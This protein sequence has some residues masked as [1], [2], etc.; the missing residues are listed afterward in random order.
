VPLSV[1]NLDDRRFQQ[2]VD[3]AKRYVQQRCPEWTDHNVSDPGVTLIETWAQM[4]E[5]VIYRLNR[6]PERL[7]IKFLDLI[8]VRL[9]PA[10]AA[11]AEITFLMSAPPVDIMRIPAGTRVA[12]L[13]TEQDEAITFTTF[14]ELVIVPTQLSRVA[15]Q[16]AGQATQKDMTEA[17]DKS[18]SFLAFSA[19]PRAGDTLVVGLS[20]PVPGNVVTLRFACSI[21]GVGVDPEHVPL[22]WEAWDGEE[23]IECDVESDGTGGLNRA[24]DVVVHVPAAHIAAV[25]DQQRAG[26]LR[27]RITESDAD[28]PAY[29]ASPRVD[30]LTA[31]TVGGNIEAANAEYVDVEHRSSPE[32]APLPS[33][34]APT[35]AGSSGP[36]STTSPPAVRRTSTSCSTP[37]R[38]RSTSDPPSGCRTER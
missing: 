12:T 16:A 18:E 14:R 20:E 28:Y 10:T 37:V 7:Y 35:T 9:Y 1:P 30:G 22:V 23:W 33:R 3:E 6:V 11:R 2:L 38:V 24:G 21:E 15:V 5:Q 19:V 8:G 27:A 26:W 34:S 36:R 17:L 4:T 32:P 29:S 13:R 31:F 25:F